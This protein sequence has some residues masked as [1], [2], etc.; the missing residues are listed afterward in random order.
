MPYSEIRIVASW[1]LSF[2]GH[3]ETVLREGNKSCVPLAIPSDV[4]H[5][6]R[7]GRIRALDRAFW[8]RSEASLGIVVRFAWSLRFT[9][10]RHTQIHGSTHRWATTTPPA[11]NDWRRRQNYQVTLG[12][13]T[14][15]QIESPNIKINFRYRITWCPW[16]SWYSLT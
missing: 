10:S 11:V 2:Q 3:I 6:Q 7:P 16:F 14:T 4:S 12:E 9:G 5:V 13:Q 15:I 8:D 1:P